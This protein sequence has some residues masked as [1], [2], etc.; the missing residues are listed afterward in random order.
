M[1]MA[2]TSEVIQAAGAT[3]FKMGGG[4]WDAVENAKLTSWKPSPGNSAKLLL[5]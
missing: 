3:V 2:V 1:L 4:T 5:P